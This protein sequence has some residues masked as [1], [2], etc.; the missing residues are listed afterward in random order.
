MLNNDDVIA[1]QERIEQIQKENL[2]RQHSPII[3]LIILYYI[4][5]LFRV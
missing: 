3:L 4:V 5:V 2:K 1:N